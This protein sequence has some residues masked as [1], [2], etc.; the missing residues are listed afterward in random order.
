[1]PRDSL[2]VL[3]VSE[4]LIS[5]SVDSI[6]KGVEKSRPNKRKILRFYTKRTSLLLPLTISILGDP[7]LH[8]V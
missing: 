3:V 7:I 2:R 5:T 4:S 6:M 1:V 8:L